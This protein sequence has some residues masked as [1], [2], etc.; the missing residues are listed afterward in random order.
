ML[1]H[2]KSRPKKCSK[3]CPKNR[4]WIQES[5][6]KNT[7]SLGKRVKNTLAH[8]THTQKRW[9]PWGGAAYIYLYIK[10]L[11]EAQGLFLLSQAWPIRLP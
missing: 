4:T 1:H 9:Y 3:K 6:T 7:K 2:A 5:M 8:V 11:F 10:C